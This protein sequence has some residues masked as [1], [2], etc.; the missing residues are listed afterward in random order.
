MVDSEVCI[1][2][3]QIVTLSWN[4]AILRCLQRQELIAFHGTVPALDSSD[5]RK[6][7]LVY[8]LNQTEICR[9]SPKDFVTLGHLH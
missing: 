9:L 8:L 5:L 2:P 1:G 4:I 3:D 6:C 7:V